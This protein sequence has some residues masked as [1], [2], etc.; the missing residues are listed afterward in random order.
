MKRFLQVSLPILLIYA[1]LPSSG[2]AQL[3][4]RLEVMRVDTDSF[5]KVRVFARAFCNGI[6]QP[7]LDQNSLRIVDGDSLMTGTIKCPDETVPISV[8]FALDRSS[9]VT[10]T[11]I[12]LIRN[13]AKEFVA[14][15]QSRQPLGDDEALV[16]SFNENVWYDQGMTGNKQIL[17]DAIHN[18]IEF[19][20]TAAWDGAILALQEVAA[21]ARNSIKAVILITDGADNSSV[22][23][24]RDVIDYS[25]TL[26]IPVY[27]IGLVYHSTFD[28]LLRLKSI[29]DSTGGMF[30]PV[31]SPFEIEA[32]FKALTSVIPN[33]QNDCNFA[34]VSHCSDGSVRRR[35][36]EAD[37]CGTTLADT[38]YY[39]V[40]VDPHLPKF[41]V[42]VDTAY[43][44]AGE[45]AYLPVIVSTQ[46][47]PSTLT[48]LEIQLKQSF[49]LAFQSVV[50]GGYLAQSGS[51]QVDNQ[52]NEL[53]IVFDGNVTIAGSDTL[54][55]IRYNADKLP[56]ET[57]VPVPF[58]YANKNTQECLRFEV[59]DGWVKII[60]RKALYIDCVQDSL[61]IRWDEATASYA[62]RDFTVRAIIRNP[63]P[64]PVT[65][66][67]AR[68]VLPSGMEMT[69]GTP[70][71]YL[72]QTVL[73]GGKQE[74]VEFFVRMLP[75][76]TARVFQLCIEV[77][78]DSTAV[79]Q[80]CTRLIVERAK[81]KM[82][83]WCTMPQTITWVDSTESYYPDVLPFTLTVSNLSELPAKNVEAWLHVPE[84]FDVDT[85][86]PVNAAIIPGTLFQSDTG[87]V[88]WLLRPKERP[89]SDNV[90]F[91]VKA[92]AGGDTVECLVRVFIPASPIRALL[93]CA[94]PQE[95]S[96]SDETKEYNPSVFLVSTDIT[97]RTTLSMKQA[98]GRITLPPFLT[99]GPGDQAQKDVPGGGVIL[100]GETKTLLW[101]INA[102][103]EPS[104]GG[105]IC[106]E[107][108]ADNY[109]GDT[110]CIPVRVLRNQQ[111][112][113]LVCSLD[114]PDTIRYTDAGYDPNPFVLDLD[115]RNTGDAPARGVFAA[116]LQGADL[117]IDPSDVALKKIADS[118][119][120][121]QSV[122]ASFKIKVLNRSVTRSDTIRI[123]VYASNGGAVVCEKVI[124]IEAV[125][126][127]ILK[128]HCSDP[129]TLTFDERTNSYIPSP[130]TVTLD[131]TNTGNAPAD[132]VTAEFLS[133]PNV[134]LAT[135]EKPSKLLSVRMNP[136][137]TG[138]M[139]WSLTA[140]PTL[141]GS[142]DTI[143]LQAKVKGTMLEEIIPCPV[144][145]NIPQVRKAE[146][147]LLCNTQTGFRVVDGHLEPGQAS[148]RLVVRNTGNAAAFNAKATISIF[149]NMT[150]PA[151]EVFTKNA[152]SIALMPD[153][154]VFTWSL[155][156]IVS[157]K[158][159]TARICFDVAADFL[160]PVKCCVDIVIPGINSN[161]GSV[162]VGCSAIDTVRGNDTTRMY[163]NPIIISAQIANP[164]SRPIDSIQV[165]I[166]LPN[167]LELATGDS[168]P[169]FIQ[170][171]DPQ[172][173]S[174]L[175]W[176]ANVIADTSTVIKER[177]V[178]IQVISNGNVQYCDLT[179]IV[180]PF[181][182]IGGKAFTVHCSAPDSIR[183][184]NS[185]IGLQPSPFQVT[186]TVTNTG[187][188]K[189]EPVSVT[190]SSASILSP[191]EP[192]FRTIA[193]GILPGTS[194]SVSWTYTPMLNK[195]SYLVDASITVQAD[196]LPVQVCTTSTVVEGVSKIVTISM[197]KGNV[198]G[199]G[200]TVSIPVEITNPDQ[201][202]VKEFRFDLRFDSTM[203]ALQNIT[204]AQTL[205]AQW[206]N[207]SATPL[208]TGWYRFT[209]TSEVPTI[210]TGV[211]FNTIFAGKVD[212]GGYGKFD[213]VT[214][215]L[216]L[217]DAE[218]SESYDITLV[219]GDIT[220]S[221]SCVLPLD[222]SEL[223]IVEQNRPNPFNPSTHITYQLPK[224]AAGLETALEVYDTFGRLVRRQ[225]EGLRDGGVH[226][227]VF[228]AS[229]LDSGLYY[230]RIHAGTYS[231]MKK[232]LY[233]K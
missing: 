50:T 54:F 109:P 230:Y 146:L 125:R 86:T 156:P 106:V 92:A 152:D 91:L 63:S 31:E 219:D 205:T 136:G 87:S 135:G 172:Q 132:S 190:L 8:G 134:T 68:L 36:V 233:V 218:P 98:R 23:L 184:I 180:V 2:M 101:I 82:T 48:H 222:A 226:T 213:I 203:V 59:E 179:I 202:A 49:D 215:P 41:T 185:Q 133:S 129:V 75:V 228:D 111:L 209:G 158:D 71:V 110:C 140:L 208:T 77:Q 105:N 123:S 139:Q 176:N 126:G 85:A 93:K 142:V 227:A 61:S 162:T 9:S 114:G 65:N 79:S 1:T 33:G 150:L 221:G 25:R 206:Q 216:D 78:A 55:L 231:K 108:M 10:G 164:D 39:R 27:T 30:I 53:T 166:V 161:P 42:K 210:G 69:Q 167:G 181:K 198:V 99:I 141:T 193:G 62:P 122:Q 40:P 7:V 177:K 51:V 117:S 26:G 38:V 171:L 12:V 212:L 11:T 207:V 232:M 73:M 74:I 225:S 169:R 170:R 143:W 201:V 127:P 103:Q 131:V 14:M 153:S 120:I 159:D 6:Q 151:N 45:E 113:R 187:T 183:Y 17:T 32:A 147:G 97:N 149:G 66:A 46:S 107:I 22:H 15:M 130:F 195:T 196:T 56:G 29:A 214:S 119:M 104:D 175:T 13:A 4:D 37:V 188:E 220:S 211:L 67:R 20:N 192:L 137:D 165:N 16:V 157:T 43:A 89:T 18:I 112:P 60:Q 189:L 28:D 178:R 118:L 186:V 217:T 138:S 163:P 160:T 95:L 83:A 21:N 115:V 34:F 224:N 174:T 223:F 100:P 116:L 168:V 3:G 128:L 64:L 88:M 19:G 76:D 102:K 121:N 148:F 124:I 80:C 72:N 199:F 229:G 52:L 173:G 81:P 90:T 197:P 145:I 144:I 96:Y 204:R 24:L 35:I 57:H 5:P 58:L 155:S 84:M 70:L 154:M 47:P 94:P 182:P 194:E 44:Y 200:Q 191:Q